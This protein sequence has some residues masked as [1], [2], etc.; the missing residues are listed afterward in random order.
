[1]KVSIDNLLYEIKY[2]VSAAGAYGFFPVYVVIISG[3]RSRRNFSWNGGHF[4]KGIEKTP[5][6]N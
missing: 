5:D 3:K 1:M 2:L 4:T 6:C